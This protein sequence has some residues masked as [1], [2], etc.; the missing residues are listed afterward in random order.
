MHSLR[1]VGLLLA[2]SA[3]FG[4]AACGDD[5]GMSQFV[6]G[7]DSGQ[8]QDVTDPFATD[9]QSGEAAI[10][11]LTIVP[12]DQTLTV[13]YGQAPPTLTYRAFVDGAI[14]SP[15]WSL[16]RGELGTIGVSSGVFNPTGTLGGLAHITA[17]DEDF[18]L[19]RIDEA[20]DHL[21]RS[22]FPA[23]RPAE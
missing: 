5:E 14:V 4:F 19:G 8:T 9:G 15:S 16:D 13:T 21:E 20:I 17:I 23:A 18:P 10:G 12:L 1:W 2:V 6:G 22:R 3:A 7:S 11:T